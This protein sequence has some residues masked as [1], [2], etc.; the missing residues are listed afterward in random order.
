VTQVSL[1]LPRG[2]CGGLWGSYDLSLLGLLRS[3]SFPRSVMS[4]PSSGSSSPAPSNFALLQYAQAR[5]R[6][7]DMRG[8]LA[9]VQYKDAA[10]RWV[11]GFIEALV[12]NRSLFCDC[13]G[14]LI[15]RRTPSLPWAHLQAALLIPIPT[16][17]VCATLRRTSSFRLPPWSGSASP[18]IS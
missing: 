10:R 12:S 14:A 16:S 3:P 5:R 17:V 15:L 7:L 1:S 13:W 18:L 6:V 2:D 4:Q 8:S 9:E 11:L